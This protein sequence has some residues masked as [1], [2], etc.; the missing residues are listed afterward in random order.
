M[1]PDLAADL[2]LLL[3]FS[4]ILF[5]IFGALLML[6]RRWFIWFHVPIALWGA[7]VNLMG[8]VCPLTPLE[9][10]YRAAAGQAGYEGGFVQHYIQPLIY[11][12][13]WTTNLGLVLGVSVLVWNI[14]IYSFV[15]YR[16]KKR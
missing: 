8:W 16:S 14:L 10:Q 12:E 13:N 4:F 3:H 9:N 7:T 2:I 6:Y 15:F 11:P 5:V 1:P